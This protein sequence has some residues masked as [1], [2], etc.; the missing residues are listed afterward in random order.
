VRVVLANIISSV[1]VD[2]LDPIADALTTDGAAIVSGILHAERPH[3]L[4]VLAGAGWRVTAEDQEDIWW[5]ASI[6][7]S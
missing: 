7:R 3:M 6:V 1:L 4:D 2:L 5:S